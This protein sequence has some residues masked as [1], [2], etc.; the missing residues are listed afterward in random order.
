MFTWYSTA[1]REGR[2]LFGRWSR[3]NSWTIHLVRG[4]ETEDRRLNIPSVLAT[5][6]AQT[7]AYFFFHFSGCVEFWACL[8]RWTGE[9]EVE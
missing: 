4:H 2:L 6:S 3:I 9:G 5:L 1:E 8:C 7:P